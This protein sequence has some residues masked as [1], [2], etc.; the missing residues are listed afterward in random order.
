MTNG[1]LTEAVVRGD[2]ASDLQSSFTP[3]QRRNKPI[4]DDELEPDES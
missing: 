4:L 2:T 3:A 1:T